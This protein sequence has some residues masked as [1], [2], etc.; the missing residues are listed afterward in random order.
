MIFL[1]GF[2]IET[3]HMTPA[4]FRFGLLCVRV[5]TL[6]FRDGRRACPG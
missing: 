3:D 5:N 4:C 6:I 1:G 2:V